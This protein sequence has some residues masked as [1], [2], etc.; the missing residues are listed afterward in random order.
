MT[1]VTGQYF[2]GLD[3]GQS[4]DFTAI[5][6]LER[7]E[8]VGEWA[9][10]MFAWRKTTAQRLR[11]LERV[12]ECAGWDEGIGGGGGRGRLHPGDAGFRYHH[13]RSRSGDF[14]PQC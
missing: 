4:Q 7:A 12:S 6:A 5:A 13:I 3:L 2:V 8:L 10:V 11:H 9:P 14:P 1:G